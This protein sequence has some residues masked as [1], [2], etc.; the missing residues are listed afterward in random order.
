MNT[1]PITH[2]A[3]RRSSIGGALLLAALTLPIFGAVESHA[4]LI[5]HL[6][7][8]EGTGTTTANSVSGGANGTLVGTGSSWTTS[9]P[10]NFISNAAYYNSGET[11]AY[12]SLPNTS[13]GALEDFTIAGWINALNVSGVGGGNDRILSKR[14]TAANSSFID[15]GFY[16]V[17]G[18]GLGIGLDVQV[19]GGPVE[20]KVASTAIT[21]SQGW[22]FVAATRK[23]DTG[24]IELYIGKPGETG[25]VRV[26][27]GTDTAGV[28]A[29][30]AALLMLGN[31]QSNT[32]RNGE[33]MFSDFRIYDTALNA[34]ELE[35]VRLQAIPEPGTA[36]MM[37]MTAPA[38]ALFSMLKAKGRSCGN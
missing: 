9:V 5:V 38:L 26:G 25:V 4:S 31:V 27:S 28:L 34:T 29:A 15:F 2:S 10:E 22:L 23:S 24:E 11:G 30:N 19:A 6:K 7:L 32:A 17:A 33:V 13:V 21:F 36:A 3:K 8:D 16:N 14:S 18:G 12:V 1:S 20:A 37:I 35:S